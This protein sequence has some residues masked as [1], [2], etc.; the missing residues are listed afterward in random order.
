MRDLQNNF[1]EHFHVLNPDFV[2]AKAQMWL[3]FLY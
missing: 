1:T 2:A 3:V